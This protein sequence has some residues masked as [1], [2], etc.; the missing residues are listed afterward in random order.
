MLS[1]RRV[2][3]WLRR[4][5]RRRRS[6]EDESGFVLAFVAVSLVVLLALAGFAVDFWHWNQEGTRLQKAGLNRADG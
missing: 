5:W 4:G 1:T 3:S 6:V 2:G